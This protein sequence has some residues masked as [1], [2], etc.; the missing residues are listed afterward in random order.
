MIVAGADGFDQCQVDDWTD[1]VQVVSGDS[2]TFG[3]KADGTVLI[4]GK[5]IGYAGIGKWA[6]FDTSTWTDIV[7]IAAN[8]YQLVGLKP[9]GSIVWTGLP[10]EDWVNYSHGKNYDDWQG[11]VA[12]DG[13]GTSMLGLRADGTVLAAYAYYNNAVEKLSE[14]QNI[15]VIA[16]GDFCTEYLAMKSDGT[17]MSTSTRQEL[18]SILSTLDLYDPQQ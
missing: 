7:S 14:F 5:S 11:I 18:I 16:S 9:D 2:T 10:Y 8:S 17:L 3:L 12:I 1:I 4:A 6:S 13:S 15:A